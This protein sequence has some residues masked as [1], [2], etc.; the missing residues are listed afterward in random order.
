MAN[1]I[2]LLEGTDASGGYLVRDTYGATLQNTIQREAATMSVSRVDRVAGKRQKYTIYAGRPTAAFVAEG[3]AK[4]VTGAE[5]AELSVDV[6]KIATTVLY[7]EELLEDAQ[8]DPRVLV[9]VDVEAA[10]T[11][12]ID[13]HALGYENGAAIVGQFNS[14]LTGTTATVELGA[15]ADAFAVAISS[16]IGTLEGNGLMADDLAIVAAVDLRQHL[17]DARMAGDL[18]ARPVYTE[19]FDREPDSLYGLRIRYSTNLDAFPAAAGKVAAVV[20][21]FRDHAIFALRRDLSI[22]FSDQATVDVGGTLHHLWQQNK[23]AAQWEMRI[24]FVAHDLNRMFETVTN[25][26]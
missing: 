15:T 20:G 11:Q 26:A 23:V 5:F 21:G 19:G 2:P 25:A 14:E 18:V 10:F 1:A 16:A 13:A 22:R 12:L 7:T 6:K 24:G 4:G 8:E 9:N 17:R 3:A